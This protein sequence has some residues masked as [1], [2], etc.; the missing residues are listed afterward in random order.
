[1]EG[2]FHFESPELDLPTFSLH[3]AEELQQMFVT[4]FGYSDI[5]FEDHPDFSK[6]FLLNS[7]NQMAVRKLFSEKLIRF[8]E[9]LDGINIEGSGNQLIA[10]RPFTRIE[11]RNFKQHKQEATRIFEQFRGQRS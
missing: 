9:E 5:N 6:K 10:Y 3:E 1:M 11:T 4:A 8:V 2:I 7:D